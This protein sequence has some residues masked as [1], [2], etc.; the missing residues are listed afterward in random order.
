VSGSA[1]D[2][3]GG[4]S[5][6]CTDTWEEVDRSVSADELLVVGLFAAGVVFGWLVWIDTGP[7]GELAAF[8][9]QVVA[10]AS[11]A[12]IALLADSSVPRQATDWAATAVFRL[13]GRVE[14]ASEDDVFRALDEREN[15]E[16]AFRRMFRFR[17][18]WVLWTALAGS[19]LWAYKHGALESARVE[20]A[21]GE[22]SLSVLL[23]LIGTLF[24]VVSAVRGGTAIARDTTGV[25]FGYGGGQPEPSAVADH[26]C[27]RLLAVS[28]FSIDGPVGFVLLLCGLVSP[29]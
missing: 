20:W 18:R 23:Q 21:V 6:D 8:V 24:L 4:R 2:D 3:G 26:Y 10:L 17:M 16:E 13:F 28:A 5:I 27:E 9:L 12:P 11:V 25:L 29:V 14:F 15:V 22:L 19:S 7:V 1:A